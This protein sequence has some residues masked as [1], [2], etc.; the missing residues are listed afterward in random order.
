[1]LECWNAEPILRPTFVD[2]VNRIELI[3]NPPRK[4]K[5]GPGESAYVNLE[6]APSRDYLEPAASTDNM[7]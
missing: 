4:Q 7:A 2:L 3:L 5:T 6:R 1:M